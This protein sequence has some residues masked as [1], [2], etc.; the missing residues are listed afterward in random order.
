MAQRDLLSLAPTVRR[1]AMAF[2]DECAACGLRVLVYCTLRS[3]EEEAALYAR[4]RT[5]P[6]PVVTNARPGESMHNPDKDGYA[7][8]FDA[9]PLDA[10]GRAA[11]GDVGRL[12]QMG[13]CGEA[14]GL[15]WAGRWSGALRERVHFQ[16]K[17]DRGI[18]G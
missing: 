10:A 13:V 8:A 3:N 17:R 7:W 14:V 12:E 6:G 16:I 4:G 15:E 1:L 18:Y 2:L 5:A 9:V 11:W